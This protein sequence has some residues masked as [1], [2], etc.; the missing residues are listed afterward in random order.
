MLSSAAVCISLEKREDISMTSA[1]FCG[2]VTNDPHLDIA[3]L[4]PCERH[5]QNQ[6]HFRA[7][8]KKRYETTLGHD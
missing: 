6:L 8:V 4:R 7:D 3:I 2:I 5:S 1:F